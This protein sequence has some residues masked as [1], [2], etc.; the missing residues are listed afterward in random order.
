MFLRKVHCKVQ[1][2]LSRIL[3]YFL[4]ELEMGSLKHSRHSLTS[5]IR[6]I[7]PP[8][9][10]WIAGI[11]PRLYQAHLGSGYAAMPGGVIAPPASPGFPRFHQ[12][13]K[14]GKKPRKLKRRRPAAASGDPA[15]EIR[16][17]PSRRSGGIW[18]LDPGDHQKKR[19]QTE[20]NT[21]W[22]W[23]FSNFYWIHLPSFEDFFVVSNLL[24]SAKS[25]LWRSPV[26]C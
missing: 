25:G 2:N 17:R 15:P 18:Q 13:A 14:Y 6:C 3:S 8:S 12:G 1:I 21:I 9:L 24:H 22:I 16:C 20:K 10:I 23:V 19:G 11:G 7:S 5:Q 4:P 26:H